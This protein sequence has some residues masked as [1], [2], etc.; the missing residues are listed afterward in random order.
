ME[1]ELK[2]IRQEFLKHRLKLIWV[3]LSALG[4][5][6]DIELVRLNPGRRAADLPG[7]NAIG[8]DDQVAYCRVNSGL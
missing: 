8:E 6:G 4:L 3:G 1:R 5:P 2:P 7:M